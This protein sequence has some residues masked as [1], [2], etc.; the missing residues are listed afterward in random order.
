MRTPPGP[1][2]RDPITLDRRTLLRRGGAWLALAGLAAGPAGC[3]G[4]LDPR[5]LV[6]PGDGDPDEVIDPPTDAG[7]PFGLAPIPETAPS[8]RIRIDQ[9]AV[10]DAALTFGAPGEM[11]TLALA[12]GGADVR[13]AG[14]V[15]IALSPAAWTWRTGAGS[16][17]AGDRGSIPRADDALVVRGPGPGRAIRHADADWP[18]TIHLSAPRAA[19]AAASG[20]PAPENLDV[21]VHADIETYVAG[22]VARELPLSWRPGIFAALAVCARSF[23]TFEA[24]SRRR[25]RW[26]LEADERSQVFGGLTE[27]AV[28]TEA[29]TRTAGAVLTYAGGILPAY[30]SSACGGLG[31]PGPVAIGSHP[32]NAI[33]PL[34]GHALGL[35]ACCTGSPRAR[36][37][38]R[39]SADRLRQQLRSHGRRTGQSDLA[40]LGRISAI[41]ANDAAATGRPIAYRIAHAAGEPVVIS[42]PHLRR[43]LQGRR[44]PGEA[45]VWSS[46][47]EPT[48]DP[49][50]GD[51]TFDGRG[52]GHGCG[53]CQYGGQA[54]ARRGIA[55]TDILRVYYPGASIERAWGPQRGQP[56]DDDPAPVVG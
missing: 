30:F 42:A 6:G 14:P 53:L 5:P 22:V 18:G 31:Q 43:A 12:G 25:R 47:L 7:P 44:Q 4:R 15:T 36:W 33:E 8:V 55:W 40:D 19:P 28:A 39:R 46:L 50:T 56:I 32:A 48:I 20:R 27:A 54:M 1:H 11:I 17:D 9:V 35:E 45:A 3:C 10:D 49:R 23:A 2:P 13:V 21:I 24:W 37:T 41:T 29:A 34:T 51:A 52:W 38:A 16:V 26:D